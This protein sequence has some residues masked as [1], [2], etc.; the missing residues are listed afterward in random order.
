MPIE[1][2]L[3]L[4]VKYLLEGIAVSVS[5]Y[6]LSKKKTGIKE[7]VALG[8]IAASS[9]FVLDL[10]APSIGAASRTGAGYGIGLQRVGFEGFE[11]KKPTIEEYSDEEYN[12]PEAFTL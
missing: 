12:V 2:I 11:G 7:T 9:F 4:I 6:F 1:E 5:A 10:F 8:V 3:I